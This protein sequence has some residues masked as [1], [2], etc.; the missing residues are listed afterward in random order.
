MKAEQKANIKD[1]AGKK[2]LASGVK[3]AKSSEFGTPR[4]SEERGTARG[5]RRTRDYDLE[6]V[7]SANRSLLSLFVFELMGGASGVASLSM[8]SLKTR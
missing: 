1:T 3:G 2:S 6:P 4:G 8:S 5:A 7:C